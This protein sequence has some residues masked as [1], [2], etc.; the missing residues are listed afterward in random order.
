MNLSWELVRA[1]LAVERTGSLSG[2]ARELGTAQPTV[3]RQV[4]ALERS[5]NAVLFTRS[6]MGLTPTEAARSML[7]FAESM[8]ASAEALVR[9]A[10]APVADEAGTVRVTASE[11]I[12]V[13]VLPAIF[14]D[15][16]RRR[17]RIHIEL[18]AT[19]R[20]LDL[21]RRNADVAVRMAKPTQTALVAKRVGDVALG[22][23]ATES[24]LLAHGIPRS[25]ADLSRGHTLVG[26]DRDEQFYAA[27]G[28]VG[29][30][31]DKRAFAFRT[32]NDV[33]QC[34]AIRAGL[35]IGVV[36]V[37]LAVRAK[38]LRRV[39]PKIAP[40]LPMWV[41]THEDLRA[42]RRVAIVFDHLVDALA[43]YARSPT[44]Q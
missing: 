3:R 44:S 7:S 35:G 43:S 14:A 34:N 40:T 36:Q 24:Y 20:N 21:L 31:L 9:H 1:F 8:A 26:R 25:I 4:E 19:D 22:L 39:L 41:V 5:L 13:E 2:A 16:S 23:Y 29:I 33:A 42:S 27:L 28:A 11:V 15:L 18:S 37:G 32:D 6:P 10:S 30:R 17:P 12:G 38:N